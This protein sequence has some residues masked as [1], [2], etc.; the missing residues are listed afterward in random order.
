MWWS[1]VSN[2]KL[3][4]VAGPFARK[5]LGQLHLADV[6]LIFPYTAANRHVGYPQVNSMEKRSLAR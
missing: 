2:V 6:V 3:N 4:V 5:L 1:I